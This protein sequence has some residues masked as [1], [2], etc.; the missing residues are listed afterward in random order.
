MAT[1]YWCPDCLEIT[2]PVRVYECD[3]DG[4]VGEERRCE[5]CNRFCSRRDEDGC[6]SCFAEVE[7]VE[8]VTDHDGAI[9][10]AEDYQ[11][12]G[13]ALAVRL[14]DQFEASRKA[15]AKKA[16]TQ[17]D[18]LL[19][20]TIETTWSEI[21]VG[22]QIVAKD[23]KG[24]IDT[25]KG[26]KILSITTAGDNA[27]APVVP[28]SLI[29]V[30]E[31]YGVRIET[32]SGDETVL[33][34]ADAPAPAPAEPA[35][36]RFILR[37][38]SD[39]HGSGLKLVYATVGL[40]ATEGRNVYVGEITGRNSEYSSFRTIVG[41]F[42]E[43]D[44]AKAFASAARAAAAD[45]RDR[46]LVDESPEQVVELETS[47]DISSHAPI[48]YATFL[49]GTDDMLGGQGVRIYTGSHER[50]MQSFS[51]LSPSVLEALA[52]AADLIAAKLTSL[53]DC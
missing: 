19:S 39:T 52:S 5:T 33:I 12:N 42:C 41:A 51:V 6:E 28:G 45:L 36:D 16:K 22:Q 31:H 30:V 4:Y 47:D 32:H 43:P 53:I 24:N 11:P 17:L 49:V 50:T 3:T 48:R 37:H 40:A 9:I 25:G 20:Q 38:G 18:A 2:D 21:T 7:K 26:A 10:R 13:K 46:V 29:V 1:G 35:Q 34:K 23:W 44:E 14:K 27:V 15:A 8:V